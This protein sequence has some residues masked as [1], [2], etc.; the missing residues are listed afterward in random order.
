VPKHVIASR[1]GIQPETL[2]R[3]LARLRGEHLIDVQDDTIVLNDV[4]ALRRL[5]SVG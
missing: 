4:E 2:S 5:S 3:V 1:L